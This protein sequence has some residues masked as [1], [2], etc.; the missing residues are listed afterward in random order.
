MRARVARPFIVLVGA[1]AA[2]VSWAARPRAQSAPPTPFIFA[3]S[4]EVPGAATRGKLETEAA[5]K[6]ARK[7]RFAEAIVLLEKVA[8]EHP[9]V[10]HDCNLS[11]AY[12]RA[13]K[14]TRAQL[15]WDVSR[16]RGAKAPDWCGPSLTTQLATAL[17]TKGYVPLTV[18][19]Q[20]PSATIEI[21]DLRF[22][23]LSLVWLPPSTYQVQAS[24]SGFDG[25]TVP[26]LVAPPSAT[27]TLALTKI[28]AATAAEVDAAPAVPVDAGVEPTAT[29]AAASTT[30]A[31]VLDLDLDP[32][33]APA[34]AARA[35][36]P[37]FAGVGVAGLGLG[38]GLA[39]HTRAL[40]T[41][42]RANMLP[43]DSMGFRDARD[44]F[45]TERALA[46]GGYVVSAAAI[47]FATWWWLGKDQGEPPARRV[48]VD[49]ANGGALLT[50]GGT[51]P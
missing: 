18:T 27:A 3:P 41:K 30:D 28:G 36:W 14:L 51:L 49:V 45:G 40:G 15:M 2:L 33:V 6:L 20:P 23:E 46:I 47:G 7:K 38:L 50:F 4:P 42:D 5:Q 19:V 24:A 22:R 29:D 31:P 39:F 44:R 21:G 9:S 11:L 13:G 48:G 16:L 37:A 26:V 35:K 34:P 1:A 25:A 17:R 43:R 8:V 12:L 10:V 32:P